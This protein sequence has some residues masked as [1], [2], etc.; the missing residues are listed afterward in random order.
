MIAH[1]LDEGGYREALKLRYPNAQARE[2]DVRQL[3]DY[4][5]QAEGLD[6][7]LG[8]VALLDSFEG[9][10]VV[11]GG[12][13]DERVALSSVHQAKGLE[14]RAVFLVWLADGRFP[15]APAL[16]DRDGEEEERRLF[17]VAATRARDELYLCYPMVHEE[18]DQARILMK[19]SRFLDELPTRPAPYE[20]W[21]IELSPPDPLLP[22]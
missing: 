3:A 6:Q 2:D 13:P 4:A 12:D 11:E 22:P 9:E 10:D 7:L 15:S 21:G 8:D 18:R 5:L 17:Y 19:P 16:R 20:K 14:W 1:V